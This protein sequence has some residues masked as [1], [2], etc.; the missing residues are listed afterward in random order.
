MLVL[1]V[2]LLLCVY[3][4]FSIVVEVVRLSVTT[5]NPITF[6]LGNVSEELNYHTGID[7]IVPEHF[8]GYSCACFDKE[9]ASYIL[10]SYRM[11]FQ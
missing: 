2:I 9:P 10:E 1:F 6:P 5:Y 3:C 7:R 4:N 11:A 8:M